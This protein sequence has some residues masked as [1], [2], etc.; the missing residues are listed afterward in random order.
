MIRVVSNSSPIIGLSKL[1]KLDLLWQLFD[2]VFI[3]EAVFREIVYGNSIQSSGSQEFEKAVLNQ[4]IKIYT[5]QNQT[6][7]DQLQGRLHRG[8]VEVIVGA[9]EL[10]IQTVMI[11]DRSAR[12]LAEALLF[13]SI[14]IV[15]VLIL[16]KKAKKIEKL[17]PYLDELIQAGFR[18]SEKLYVSSLERVG[19]RAELDSE[20]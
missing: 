9:R 18:I 16:A 12:N 4:T 2:E 3:P 14:G 13:T 11:D 7:V 1:G 5:V 15:G 8:E 17:K 20:N 6:M 10:D 19:E